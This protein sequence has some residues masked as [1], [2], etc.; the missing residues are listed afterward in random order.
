MVKEDPFDYD[1]F[2]ETVYVDDHGRKLTYQDQ[3]AQM[4]RRVKRPVAQ[5]EEPVQPG[6]KKK[7]YNWAFFLASMFIGLGI[8]ATTGGPFGL[9]GGLGVGFLFFVDPIYDRV[10]RIVKGKPK[11]E[12]LE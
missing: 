2:V 12:E 8:T 1:V 7:K 3:P 4:K 10:M 11:W 6:V 5:K 9:F